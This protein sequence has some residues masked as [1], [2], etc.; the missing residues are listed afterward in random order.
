MVALSLHM[1]SRGPAKS[2]ALVAG[3]HVR[4]YL[5]SL[6]MAPA[7]SMFD[8]PGE[9]FRVCDPLGTAVYL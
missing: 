5:E 6:P 4:L 2:D 3:D 7:I 8:D 1:P 9:L